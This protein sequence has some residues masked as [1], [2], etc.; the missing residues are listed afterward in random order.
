MDW[1]T[2]QP[3]K[4]RILPEK[5]PKRSPGDMGTIGK[6]LINLSI[7][8]R[9]D[10]KNDSFVPDSMQASSISRISVLSVEVAVQLLVSF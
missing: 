9:I 6:M 3:P 1:A 10:I 5:I 8:G 7:P 2:L 4:N